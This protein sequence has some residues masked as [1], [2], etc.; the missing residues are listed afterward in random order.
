MAEQF[1]KKRM[2]FLISLV[3]FF[4]SSVT[5]WFI[6]LVSFKGEV[7]QRVIAYI[8]GA[9]FWL[10]LATGITFL[11]LVNRMRKKKQQHK[12]TI[13]F[14]WFFRN[15]IALVFDIALIAGFIGIFIVLFINGLNQWLSAGII[16]AF[17]FSLEMHGM[18][19]GEN[20]KYAF[21]GNKNGV[22]AYHGK[23]RKF[24]SDIK[25]GETLNTNQEGK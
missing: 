20:F 5:I 19:N 8:L 17:I 3:G 16:F 7:W 11:V 25:S 12:K 15:R 24:V 4:L 9:I 1:V 18:F 2:W 6:P 13:P 10:G 22:R 21:G 23:K 14:I